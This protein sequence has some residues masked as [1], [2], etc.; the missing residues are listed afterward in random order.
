MSDYKVSVT[1]ESLL[2]IFRKS[3]KLGDLN[4]LVEEIIDLLV[5]KNTDY[6]DAW[7]RYGIFTPLIRI[8]DKILRVET[9][10]TGEHALV[11]E[12]GIDDTLRD[13]VGYGILALLWLDGN[14]LNEFGDR[15]CRQIPEMVQSPI[16]KLIMDDTVRAFGIPP[17]ELSK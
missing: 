17:D 3:I 9:L 10:S 16:E 14:L 4:K 7:Q 8:N 5:R 13:I 6:A 11:A 1:R 15:F 2:V 12:E